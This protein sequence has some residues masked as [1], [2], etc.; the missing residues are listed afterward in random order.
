MPFS[1]KTNLQRWLNKQ[2]DP[3]YKTIIT[4]SNKKIIRNETALKIFYSNPK[5]LAYKWMCK[6]VLIYD[7][8]VEIPCETQ[9]VKLSISYLLLNL[10]IILSNNPVAL[11]MISVVLKATM[12]KQ[13]SWYIGNLKKVISSYKYD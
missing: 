12:V 1:Y 9:F 5:I 7:I 3:E 8:I 11:S 6:K 10:S 4:R 13:I 2:V